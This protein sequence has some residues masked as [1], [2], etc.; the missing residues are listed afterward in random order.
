M[1]MSQMPHLLKCTVVPGIK[2]RNNS[3]LNGVRI[4]QVLVYKLSSF[5]KKLQILVTDRPT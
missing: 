2:I 4:S 3:H 1:K 5:F